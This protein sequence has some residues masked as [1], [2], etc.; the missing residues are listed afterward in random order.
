MLCACYLQ[1]NAQFT[2]SGSIVDEMNEPVAG[3]EIN[4]LPTNKTTITDESGTFQFDDVKAGQYTLIVNS[5]WWQVQES[6]AVNKNVNNLRITANEKLYIDEVL[7]SSIRFGQE[8]STA[9]TT[10]QQADIVAKAAAVDMPFI[11]QSTPSLVVTS[12]AG[13]GVGYTGMRIRGSD[14]TRINVTINGIP[15]NDA[16]SQN[17][18]FVDLPDLAASAKNIQIQRGVGTSSNGAAS[19]GA[20]VNVNTHD[21]SD[22]A[23]ASV[24][25]LY[26]SFNTKKASL[27]FNSGKVGENFYLTGRLSKITSDGY[28]DRSSS[29]LSSVAISPTLLIGNSSLRYDLLYGHERTYQAWYGID[30]GQL[31]ADRTFNPAGTERASAPYPDQVDDY[32]QVHHQLHFN[33]TLSDKLTVGASAHYTPGNGFYEEYKADELRTDYGFSAVE[34]NGQ[35]QDETDLV[36]RRWLDN[37]FYGLVASAQYEADEASTLIVGGGWN[38]YDGRHFGEVIWAE[39][40]EGIDVEKKYYDNVADKY[41]GN[42]Y[43]KYNRQLNDKVNA[44]ADIQYRAISYEFEGPDQD[45]TLTDQSDKLNFI[46][47]KIGLQY[48]ANDGLLINFFSG[49]ANKEPNRSDYTESSPLSRPKSEWLWNTEVG[50]SWQP[51]SSLRFNPNIYYM[52]YQDQLALNG[53]INDVGAATRINVDDSYRAGIELDF[54]WQATDKFRLYGNGTFSKNEIKELDQFVDSYDADF[55]WLEQV[56]VTLEDTPLPFSPSTI[57]FAGI[58]GKVLET[59]SSMLSLFASIKHVGKQ[60]IDLSGDDANTLASYETVDAGVTLNVKNVIGKSIAINARVN[61]I[62]DREYSANAWSYKY[63]FDGATTYSQG[64]YPQALRHYSVAI[65]LDF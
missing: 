64:F 29:D 38:H 15:L 33:S 36:R 37:H 49:I 35:V 14:Q 7:I 20:S 46:N 59:G 61:N 27:Q 31:A 65:T 8:N 22:E 32:T 2:V 57:A 23:S 19:F 47:P 34:I 44:F 60:H 53:Q 6:I 16:E 4:L 12:D 30:A 39:Y 1:V 3:Q 48:R 52:K 13:A 63:L 43:V 42:I 54:S 28:I 21:F 50:A 55:N 11:L 25:G 62:F 10:L 5:D 26:G 9:Q 51:M 18:F 41:D 24:T 58:D 56:K 45:G 40:A 17:V